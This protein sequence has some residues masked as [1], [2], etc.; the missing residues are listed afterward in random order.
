MTWIPL[1]KR[2]QHARAAGVSQ[3]ALRVRLRACLPD[4]SEYILC[5]LMWLRNPLST[6]GW[7]IIRSGAGER[8]KKRGTSDGF[9]HL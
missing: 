6:G 5:L 4:A 7:E 8:R 3:Y 1:L 9:R 2:C